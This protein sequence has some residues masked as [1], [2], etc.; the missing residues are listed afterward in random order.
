MVAMLEVVIFSS[1]NDKNTRWSVAFAVML[2]FIS[3]GVNSY[4]ETDRNL[5]E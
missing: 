2:F 1:K 3:T 5:Q 4:T